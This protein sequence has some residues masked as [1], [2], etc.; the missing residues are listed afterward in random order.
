MATLRLP[1]E[2]E[3]QSAVLLA[4][5]HGL[6]DWADQLDSIRT[7]Y[8]AF[9]QTLL[10]LQPLVLLVHPADAD[11]LPGFQGPHDL[12]PIVVDFD[13]TWCRDYGPISLLGADRRARALDF[14]FNGWGGKYDARN[15]N[16]VNRTL[17]AQAVFS[18]FARE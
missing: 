15:D 16:A 7:E 17:L 11:E 9:I 4:W 13:D 14:I 8:S 18:S 3:P 10:E 5:P 2:W 1:A 12:H 6:G